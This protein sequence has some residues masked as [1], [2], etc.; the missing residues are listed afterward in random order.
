[1]KGIAA[2]A[3]EFTI[4]VAARTNETIGAVISDIDFTEQSWTI[5]PERMKA[6]AEHRVPLPTQALSVIREAIGDR[7]NGP[8]F[9]APDGQP[10]SDAAMAAVLKRMGYGHVTVHGMRATFGTW[11]EECTDYPDGVRESALAH[12]YKSETVAS[13]QRGTKFEKR[14]ALMRDWADYLDSPASILRSAL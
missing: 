8:I 13:Y 7:T 2:R 3:L 4:L 11:A 5:P 12:K 10:L 14:R 6:T 9:L 1:M